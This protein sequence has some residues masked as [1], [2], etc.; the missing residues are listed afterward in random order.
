MRRPSRLFSVARTAQ[1]L[2]AAQSRAILLDK[3]APGPLSG[4]VNSDS[5]Q[6][7]LKSKESTY[8]LAVLFAFSFL[9]QPSHAQ[10]TIAVL[11]TFDDPVRD[12]R[13]WRCR[14]SLHRCGLRK[15]RV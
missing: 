5:G 2:A 8:S 13:S 15:L 7:I 6:I 12:K 14:R 1:T 9:G 4:G 10:I 11:E 3:P